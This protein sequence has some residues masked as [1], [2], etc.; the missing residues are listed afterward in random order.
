VIKHLELARLHAREHVEQSGLD[1]YRFVLKLRV[2]EKHIQ[3]L[4]LVL[5]GQRDAG[6][7]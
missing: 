1:R 4:R 5:F 3:P 7:F 6:A 2:L